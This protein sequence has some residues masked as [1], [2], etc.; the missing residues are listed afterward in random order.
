MSFQKDN[1]SFIFTAKMLFQ[2]PNETLLFILELAQN[3]SFALCCSR[4]NG[5]WKL[6]CDSKNT[7]KEFVEKNDIRMFLCVRKNLSKNKK[8]KEAKLGLKRDFGLEE[9]KACVL[10]NRHKLMDIQW[11]HG[12]FIQE[13]LK[14]K[15]FEATAW[16][17]RWCGRR[18]LRA[19]YLEE[20]M[21]LKPYKLKKLKYSNLCWYGNSELQKKVE[22]RYEDCSFDDVSY[23]LLAVCQLSPNRKKISKGMQLAMD[24]GWNNVV[25]LTYYILGRFGDLSRAVLVQ[26]IEKKLSGRSGIEWKN[27]AYV[28]FAQGCIDSGDKETAEK[29][30][31]ELRYICK[32][33]DFEIDRWTEDTITRA[34]ILFPFLEPAVPL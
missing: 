10:N 8:R 12:R 22:T 27:R 11:K 7:I 2:L 23:G 16:L 3:S 34:I 19:W 20:K 9:L 21:G 31:E 1:S 28:L 26:N 15:N 29:A 17:A 24:R 4:F 32:T 14:T 18:G 13:K 5:I 6:F 25:D 30:K 33:K